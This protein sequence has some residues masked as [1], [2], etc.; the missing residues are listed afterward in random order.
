MKILLVEDVRSLAALMAARLRDSG[1]EVV[2]AENGRMAV[3]LFR[4]TAPDLV[5]MDIEMPVMSG[6]EA[7]CEIR[8]I[9]AQEA[10]AWTPIIFLTASDTVEN[11]L[12]AIEAGADD[13]MAKSIPEEVL[14]AKMK[15]MARI[16][17]LRRRLAAANEKLAS[18]ASQDGLTGLCN[19]RGMDRRVDSLWEEASAQGLP[20]TLLMI[21]V[22]R[23]KQFNDH[24]GH[25]EGDD[26]LK[27]IARTLEDTIA[28]HVRDICPGAF[29]ARYGGEEFA[30]VM[31][32]IGE[33]MGQAVTEQVLCAIR[34]RGLP[35]DKT[36]PWG[37]ATASIGG[38]HID[39]AEGPVNRLF[40]RA[41]EC[42]YQ[43]K[44]EGR[45]RAVYTQ[46]NRT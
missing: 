19:R 31:P 11:F 29:A 24:Y 2:L 43:A 3:E 42:L 12:H 44:A 37:I 5:L 32:G 27:Q 6:F 18:L 26:C 46:L 9:E 33:Q 28:A 14:Q 45:N 40:R 7:T 22:D 1:H 30:L 4:T 17:A 23:F 20:F 39:R 13:F 15:A 41:D 34:E 35:H 36:P 16:A 8:A 25:L 21:D 38:V 10:W